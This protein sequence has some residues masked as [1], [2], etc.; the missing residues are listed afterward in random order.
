MSGGVLFL[1]TFADNEVRLASSEPAIEN[2]TWERVL[3]FCEGLDYHYRIGFGEASERTEWEF[4]GRPHG[5]T[6]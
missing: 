6:N 2:K 3:Q 5:R 4:Q 1:G